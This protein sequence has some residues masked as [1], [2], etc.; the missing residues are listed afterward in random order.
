MEANKFDAA[1]RSSS[2]LLLLLNLS[3]GDLLIVLLP[4]A[5]RG[6]AWDFLF[7]DTVHNARSTTKSIL[8]VQQQKSWFVSEARP[9]ITG[10][11]RGGAE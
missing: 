5:F 2:A 8:S 6:Q 7:S 3:T 1:I 11:S 9:R 4:A 10:R